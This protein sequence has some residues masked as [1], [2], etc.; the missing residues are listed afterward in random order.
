MARGLL[1]VGRGFVGSAVARAGVSHADFDWVS[2]LAR[3][4]G[5]QASE[6]VMLEGDAREID[7]GLAA[8][9]LRSLRATTTHIVLATG[10]ARLGLS[11]AEGHADHVAPALGVIN[12]ARSCPL[13]QQIVVISSVLA[14]APAP[15]KCRSDWL[16]PRGHHRNFYEWAKQEVERCFISAN[17]PTTVVRSGQ[18]INSRDGQ[19]CSTYPFGL[20]ESLPALAAGWPLLIDPNSRYWCV[21]VD[22]LADVVVA[23]IRAD[24]GVASTW[25]VHPDSPT[26]GQILDVL[27]LRHGLAAKR[28]S[29]GRLGEAL[30]MLIRPSWLGLDVPRELL[31]YS[32]FD[33]DL[34]LKVLTGLV[35]TMG[36]NLGDLWPTVVATTDHE[37]SRWR[38]DPK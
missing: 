31:A 11:L 4:A 25:C 18:V 7:F 24:G 8:Q 26:I 15:A 34:D 27:A 5:Q 30:G 36:I 29:F 1:V 23:A 32:Q 19:W 9:D 2:T 21:P 17:V 10:G 28:F 38:G 35:E 12:F 20:F 6:T 37:L 33:M 16:P 3:G 13:L 22:L 14:A